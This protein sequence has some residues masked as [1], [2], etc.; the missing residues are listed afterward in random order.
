MTTIMILD[1]ETMTLFR[2]IVLAIAS[3]I[4]T[5]L[6]YLCMCIFGGLGH[7]VESPVILTMTPFTFFQW[8][9]LVV[10]ANVSRPWARVPAKSFAC[11]YYIWMLYYIIHNWGYGLLYDFEKIR[12]L[13]GHRF[14][15][16]FVIWAVAFSLIHV[17]IWLPGLITGS[18][19]SLVRKGK[20]VTH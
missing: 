9:V 7:G 12:E 14:P 1:T 13:S 6:M 19:H 10:L 2:L 5:L 11:L 15:M 17:L 16:E 20:G 3:G 8:P 4:A 18:V